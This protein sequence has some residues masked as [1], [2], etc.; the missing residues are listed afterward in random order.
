M[1][2]IQDTQ[3]LVDLRINEYASG[4]NLGSFLRI[5]STSEG[6]WK[7]DYYDYEHTSVNIS[8]HENGDIDTENSEIITKF[9]TEEVVPKHG[10]W[11]IPE[12]Y[13]K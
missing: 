3:T 5:R 11:D 7:A 8:Y 6:E 10:D 1:P 12:Y 2:P 13:Q 4:R 9:E